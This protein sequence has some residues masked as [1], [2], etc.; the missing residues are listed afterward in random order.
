MLETYKCC[1]LRVLDLL[2][3]LSHSHG[4]TLTKLEGEDSSEDV[5][6]HKSNG[7]TSRLGQDRQRFV[8]LT[9]R[10]PIN[11]NANVR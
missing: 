5:L 11:S 4:R 1:S 7:L 6:L 3:E 2:F 9:I 10:A 8:Q